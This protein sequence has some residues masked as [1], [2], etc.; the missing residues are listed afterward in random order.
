MTESECSLFPPNNILK[1]RTNGGC[2][3]PPFTTKSVADYCL[4]QN[5]ATRDTLSSAPLQCS[6]QFNFSRWDSL[7]IG[8]SCC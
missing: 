8:R 5:R 1:N 6:A 4:A 2:G 7:P 3:N